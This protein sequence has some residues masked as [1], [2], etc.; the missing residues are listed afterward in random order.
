MERKLTAGPLTDREK[1]IIYVII[2]SDDLNS[3]VVKDIKN[4]EKYDAKLIT[5]AND[6]RKTQCVSISEVDMYDI[7]DQ[8]INEQD[9]M[10]EI[11]RYMSE[12]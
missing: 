11:T 8:I 6:M 5:I 7:I 3:K 4:T 2:L 12:I 9:R 10:V 1:M